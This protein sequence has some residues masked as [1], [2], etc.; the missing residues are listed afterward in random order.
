M[1]TVPGRHTSICNIILW[2]I[3]GAEDMPN[4]S[5][6]KQKRPKGVINVVSNADSRARGTCQKPE[7]ASSFERMLAPASCPS[8][9]STDGSGCRSRWTLWLSLVRSTQRRTF[10][11]GFGTTT[12]P[13]HQSVG[14]S[15][16]AI[17]PSSSI[18]S[19]SRLTC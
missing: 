15:T 9:W 19:S 10:P 13:A 1:H 17:T 8:T 14:C 5:L 11:F 3:S 18:R 6:W 7:L 4:G 12:K 16:L 2:K